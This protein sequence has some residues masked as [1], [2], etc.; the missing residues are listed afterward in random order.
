MLIKRHRKK[1]LKTSNLQVATAQCCKYRDKFYK[2]I[3]LCMTVPIGG[4][5]FAKYCGKMYNY[6]PF[7][8][9]GLI[10]N[11][12]PFIQSYILVTKG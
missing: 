1:F 5:R 7:P 2:K 3:S 11:L 12:H 10:C 6:H 4:A 9:E 8:Y